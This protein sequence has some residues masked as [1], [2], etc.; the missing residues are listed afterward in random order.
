MIVTLLNHFLYNHYG[1][2]QVL[3]QN[4]I[5]FENCVKSGLLYVKDIFNENGLLKSSEQII[6]ILNKKP[7]WICEYKITQK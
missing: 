1:R 6:D 3:R 2:T 4:I 5:Y 7:N